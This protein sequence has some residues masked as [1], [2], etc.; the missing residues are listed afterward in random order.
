MKIEKFVESFNKSVG[1]FELKEV[2]IETQAKLEFQDELDRIYVNG[3]S[4][5]K[6]YSYTHNDF[7]EYLFGR[8]SDILTDTTFFIKLFEN[9]VVIQSLPE[10]ELEQGLVFLPK[11]KAI[12]I[13][14]SPQLT[15]QREI[16]SSLIK[17]GG[18]Y[19]NSSKTDSE[20]Q[21]LATD[22]CEEIIK[23]S[24][25]QCIMFESNDCWNNWFYD[26]AW[27]YSY[28]IIN[29]TKKS[30]WTVFVTDTD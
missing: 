27:D 26:V 30:I 4:L 5:I 29:I 7:I 2:N 21:T 10:F 11:F 13:E 22:F 15:L 3:G 23:Y 8:R 14:R 20:I 1:E 24:G 28:I 6:S 25:D 19:V 17:R 9:K 12:N 16:L 18:A